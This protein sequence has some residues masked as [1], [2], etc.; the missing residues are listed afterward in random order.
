MLNE[1]GQEVDQED[2]TNQVLVLPICRSRNLV[3]S[4]IMEFNTTR[5]ENKSFKPIKVYLRTQ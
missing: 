2:K 4:N 3:N 1:D 5:Y